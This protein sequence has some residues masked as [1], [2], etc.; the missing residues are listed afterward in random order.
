M[1]GQAKVYFA[2]RTYSLDL[3]KKVS[4]NL[5]AIEGRG[6]VRWLDYQHD[7]IDLLASESSHL[8][9]ATF[10]DLRYPFDDEKNIASLSKDFEEWIYREN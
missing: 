7:S 10:G 2:N 3:E 9:N 6:L 4:V 1:V 5:P 8:P